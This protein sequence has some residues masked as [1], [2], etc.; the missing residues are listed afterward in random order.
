MVQ[1][2]D[3][4]QQAGNWSYVVVFAIAAAEASLF[5]GLIIPG[6]TALLIAGYLAWRGSLSLVLVIVA[7]V[8]GAILGDSIG[9]EVGRRVGAKLRHGRVGRWVGVERWDRAR[10]H[11]SKWGG[12]AVFIGRFFAFVRPTVPAAA[13]DAGIP[14][15]EFL[16]WNIAG[17]VLWS[18]LHVG[19]GYLAGPSYRAAG[20]V[21]S[22]ILIAVGVLAVAGW[23]LVR[24]RRSAPEEVG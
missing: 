7:S 3:V 24:R 14:Y 11:L 5:V 15:R 20:R 19:I 12:K 22:L 2:D 10:A 8:V 17:G 6:E 21:L 16:V 4:I 23:L 1:L 18:V 13:G 9:Y